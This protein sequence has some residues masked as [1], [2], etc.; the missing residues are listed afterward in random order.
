MRK[1]EAEIRKTVGT[2]SRQATMKLVRQAVTLAAVDFG[3]RQSWQAA[4]TCF[5]QGLREIGAT[6][7]DL[8][9][10]K[11]DIMRFVALAYDHTD[12]EREAVE[13]VLTRALSGCQ[14]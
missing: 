2:K 12:E 13:E 11:S 10:L 5:G 3:D 8:K 7:D 9:M 1:N 6:E 14:F 4:M